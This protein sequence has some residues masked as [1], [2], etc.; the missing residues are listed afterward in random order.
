M[1]ISGTI[2][3]EHL[4][5]LGEEQNV[6]FRI[7]DKW[8]EEKYLSE[9]TVR[10]YEL[11]EGKLERL[12]IRTELHQDILLFL[13]RALLALVEPHKLGKVQFAGLRVR[14]KPGKIREPD[15]VFILTQH[16]GRRS[17]NSWEGADL[18][19]EVVSTDDPARD[20]DVKRQE[21]AQAGIREYWIVDPQKGSITVF[22]LKDGVYEVYGEF[23]QGTRAASVL[24]NGFSVDVAAALKP[25]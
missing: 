21:Y 23:K 19:M 3:R 24:L 12:P 4:R 14:T 10:G 20:W 22:V 7:Q 9:V 8:N 25:E 1:S 16:F 2:N 13:L 15:I 6:R 17:N 11:C 18:A 5:Q